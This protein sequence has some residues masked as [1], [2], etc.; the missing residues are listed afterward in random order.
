MP[1]KKH[2]HRGTHEADGCCPAG[3]A[4]GQCRAREQKQTPSFWAPIHPAS[5]RLVL[6]TTGCPGPGGGGLLSG[7]R[8]GGI[9]PAWAGTATSRCGGGTSAAG[10]GR[11][12]V[13]QAGALP[14]YR[15]CYPGTYLT[16]NREPQPK[17]HC[18]P[19][20]GEPAPAPG[21]R[22]LAPARHGRGH[23]DRP[24]CPPAPRP[25]AAAAAPLR[26]PLGARPLTRYG[27][28]R[29]I[30]VTHAPP[31]PSPSSIAGLRP[32]PAAGAP[33]RSLRG[34]AAPPALLP[35]RPPPASRRP[36]GRERSRI[37]R[38]AECSG[39][40][41]PAAPLLVPPSRVFSGGTVVAERM[42]GGRS[43]AAAYRGAGGQLARASGGGEPGA[44]GGSPCRR[45]RPRPRPLPAPEAR[46][47]D[48][49]SARPASQPFKSAFPRAAKCWSLPP[50]PASPAA[51]GPCPFRG[52]VPL[53]RGPP[54]PRSI[55]WGCLSLGTPSALCRELP[56]VEGEA[57][58]P[59]QH[60]QESPGSM[61]VH[62]TLGQLW[63]PGEGSGWLG[64]DAHLPWAPFC[65]V[66]NYRS[67]V[68][69]PCCRRGCTSAGQKDAPTPDEVTVRF[70]EN[71]LCLG[72]GRPVKERKEE[73]KHPYAVE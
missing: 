38:R 63:G 43:A 24:P 23:T 2:A 18:R 30:R 53:Q 5:S 15:R 64:L 61:V 45:P 42:G 54:R 10:G 67:T 7:G 13:P 35:P 66:R 16:Q 41:L 26:S 12:R 59:A 32:A 4:Q 73:M 48:L 49:L 50:P 19:A 21:P 9:G 47:S 28:R 37:T 14:S 70:W 68:P 72:K 11:L 40:S 44:G 1:K 69:A 60:Y 22:P 8:R 29:G 34:D 56:S 31:P 62:K 3:S 71:G 52:T 17:P 57:S 51:E 33:R 36:R 65:I 20:P 58:P 27:R 6:Q 46:S 39:P 55:S 25:E